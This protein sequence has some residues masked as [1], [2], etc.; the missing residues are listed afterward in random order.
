MKR[1]LAAHKA[2]WLGPK[3][4]LLLILLA[5]LLGL[6]SLGCGFFLDDYA[7][8][9]S[10]R[11]Q[12]PIAKPWDIFCFAPG[13]AGIMQSLMDT[14]PYP[15]FCV[16]T[17]KIH[18]FRPLTSLLMNLDYLVFD[19]FEPGY[20]L[21]CALW[22]AILAAV[23][24]CLMR[25]TLPG[26]LGILMLL[27]FV[28]DESHAFP[29]S[30]WSN[31]NAI[32]CVAITF[33][34]V[35]AHLRWRE[36][37]WKPGLPLSMLGYILGLLC[38]ESA[39]SVLAYV[40]AYEM[41]AAPGSLAKRLSSIAP[42]A[43]LAC[44]Y[45][46]FYK[47]MGFGVKGMR[48]YLDPMAVPMEFAVHAPAR[49]LILSAT[50]FFTFPAEAPAM[51]G[52]LEWPSAALGLL[53]LGIV[54][55]AL[56]YAWPG[57]TPEERRSMRWLIA[58]A[59][60]STAPLLAP[61]T[62]GRLLFVPSVGGSAVLAVL[63]RH[64]WRVW[65]TPASPGKPLFPARLAKTLLVVFVVLHIAFA[66]SSWPTIAYVFGKMTRGADQVALRLKLDETQIARQRVTII[67][68]PDPMVGFYT[69][70]VRMWHDRPRSQSWS[71]L[72]IAPFAHIVTRI[73]ADT[74][75]LTFQNGQMFTTMPE[76]LMRPPEARFQPGDTVR[77][78]YFDATI[79]ECGDVGPSKLKFQFRVP[80]DDP[81]CVFLIWKDG[82]LQRFE[83]PPIDGSV[84]IPQD[85]GL[86]DWF[87]G[88]SSP[89]Q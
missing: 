64:G 28:L 11:G 51:L 6:F 72:S 27:L 69:E 33:L 60:L 10:I 9:A 35:L 22:Y 19:K 56:R 14:G 40:L 57:L 62:S 86:P 24:A 52:I 61:F 81:A 77:T 16:R 83:M 7:H 76:E 31:R 46:L 17:M 37:G 80:L 2:L 50:Q 55:L 89:A 39:L 20:H 73:A 65:H 47:V 5:G 23:I 30:W 54:I 4:Y 75:L 78:K 82:A 70:G 36:N 41:F 44:A 8:L 58:G 42:A 25:R 29:V 38:G 3:A 68:A 66:A 67:N 88:T 53:L 59:A 12:N 34:G 71:A 45:L 13:D 63:M 85:D 26:P 87:M 32:T 43:L 48:V 84:S 1:F 74:F 79:L 49:F 21:H 18:F 15:W